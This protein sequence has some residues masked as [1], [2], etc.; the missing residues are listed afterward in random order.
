[1]YC[2]GVLCITISSFGMIP[3]TTQIIYV[4]NNANPIKSP[5]DKLI[6]LIRTKDIDTIKIFLQTYPKLVNTRDDFTGLTP[7]ALAIEKHDIKWCNHLL[8]AKASPDFTIEY[9]PERANSKGKEPIY[10]SFTFIARVY[11]DIWKNTSATE[12]YANKLTSRH[13]LASNE[14]RKNLKKFF[15]QMADEATSQAKF[16][17]CKSSLNLLTLYKQMPVLL[18]FN[19]VI[20][21]S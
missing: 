18:K 11:S 4:N 1:M 7:L 3:N 9:Y 14:N 13:F 2:A 6:E 12:K 21:H 10:D 8:Q 15:K 5:G 20:K 16:E 19:F 17:N